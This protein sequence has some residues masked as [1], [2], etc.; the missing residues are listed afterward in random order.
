VGGMA[1]T[2]AMGQYVVAADIA[3]APTVEPNDAAQASTSD[4]QPGEDDL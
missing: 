4:R 3:T 1:G 2:N